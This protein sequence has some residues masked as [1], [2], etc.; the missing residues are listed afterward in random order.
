MKDKHGDLKWVQN[1][2]PRVPIVLYTFLLVFSPSS[3]I[4]NYP[5]KSF[6][7]VWRDSWILIAVLSYRMFKFDLQYTEHCEAPCCSRAVAGCNFLF[8]MSRNSTCQ[9]THCHSFSRNRTMG[10]W[11]CP[12]LT[13]TKCSHWDCPFSLPW[14]PGSNICLLTWH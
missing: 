14:T 11:Y 9:S 2:F 5:Q 3:N 12:W 8:D 13:H 10:Q 6:L 7:H 1:I 4:I